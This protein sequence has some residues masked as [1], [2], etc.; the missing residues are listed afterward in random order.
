MT[1]PHDTPDRDHI[2]FA[3]RARG[4]RDPLVWR[5][6]TFGQVTSDNGW[7]YIA[8]GKSHYL[9]RTITEVMAAVAA[10]IDLGEEGN[11]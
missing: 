9:D 2:R 8:G 6:A 4:V 3:L 10:M 11:T 1:N 7:H 5:F